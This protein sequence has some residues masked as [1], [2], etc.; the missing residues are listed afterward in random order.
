[1]HTT[2]HVISV[3]NAL[4]GLTGIKSAD[5][6]GKEQ[7]DHKPMVEVKSGVEVTKRKSLRQR[8]PNLMRYSPLMEK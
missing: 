5:Q 3:T 6:F 8:F 2:P 4:A 1:M 7:E